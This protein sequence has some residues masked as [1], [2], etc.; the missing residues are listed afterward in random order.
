MS[1]SQIKSFQKCPRSWAYQ[2]LLKVYPDEDKWNLHFGSGVHVGLEH[3][4]NGDTLENA[5]KETV[6]SCAKEAPDD[7]EMH[8]QAKSMVIGYAKHFYPFYITNWQTVSS[9]EWYEYFPHPLIKMRGSRD[10]V[11][12]ARMDP[13]YM[14]LLDFKTTGMKDGGDLGK[15]IKTNHQLALYS[16]SKCREIGKWPSEQGLIFLQKPRTKSI[17]EWC[18]RAENDPGLYSMKNEPFTPDMAHYALAV[19]QEV[20][21]TGLQMYALAKAFDMGGVPAL[22]MA[23]PN[24]NACFEYGRMC[25]FSKGCHNNRPM[26]REMLQC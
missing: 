26:H 10:N 7:A 9:E 23:I 1:D 20:V 21:A 8:A 11:S 12:V 25:G 2:K 18:R 13:N 17:T 22:E 24:L 6:A 15:T 4:H 5:T 14:A 16:V 19:E 3:L